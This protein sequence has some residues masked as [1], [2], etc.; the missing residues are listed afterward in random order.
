M[1]LNVDQPWSG[2]DSWSQQCFGESDGLS[3]KAGFTLIDAYFGFN[4]TY[5]QLAKN[6]GCLT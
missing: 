2:I 5:D 3:A 4:K 6:C 1:K